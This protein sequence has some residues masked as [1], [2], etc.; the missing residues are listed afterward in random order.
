MWLRAFP[1][2]A[3]LLSVSDGQM[4]V[5]DDND[6]AKAVFADKSHGFVCATEPEVD[7]QKRVIDF[8]TSARTHDSFEIGRDGPLGQE[9][10]ACTL[11]RLSTSSNG[12]VQVLF[13][14]IDRT[15]DRAMEKSL[16]R[17]L[18][19]DSLTA[20]P[21]RTGFGEEVDEQLAHPA[22]SD[23][24]SFAI[25]AI[26]LIRFSRVN[27]SLGPLAGDEL[28]ITVAKR[29]K[30][31]LRRGDVL[32]RIGGNEFAVFARLNNGL[33]DALYIVQRDRKSVV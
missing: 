26:D 12:A 2:P 1:H 10:M 14:A 29:L 30:S 21:N 17:E 8:V 23:S 25:L 15:N 9:F 18:L 33:S 22:L 11:G 13:T 7:L 5:E 19:S 31:S 4:V 6:A 27:E 20:L 24:G 16:R 32:A 3:A 28:I